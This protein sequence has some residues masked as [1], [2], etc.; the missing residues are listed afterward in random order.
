VASGWADDGGGVQPLLG[1]F[2]VVVAGLAGSL[3]LANADRSTS[4]H[5]R[6]GHRR[7][8]MGSTRLDATCWMSSPIAAWP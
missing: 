6:G 4:G 8:A 1:S 5:A 3:R 2:T 7:G